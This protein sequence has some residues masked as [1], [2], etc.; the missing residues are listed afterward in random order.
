MLNC[1]LLLNYE[2][3]SPDYDIKITFVGSAVHTTSQVL[4]TPLTSYP[5]EERMASLYI[6]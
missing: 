4:P 3:K 2:L 6:R 5:T 1:I